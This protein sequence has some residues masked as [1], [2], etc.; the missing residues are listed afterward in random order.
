MGWL[1]MA[2]LPATTRLPVPGMTGSGGGGW[3]WAWVVGVLLCT[4]S[5]YL[6]LPPCHPGGQGTQTDSG[7]SGRENRQDGCS[8]YLHRAFLGT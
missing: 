7:N 4:A 3:A 6:P 2:C 8:P 1:T 5:T